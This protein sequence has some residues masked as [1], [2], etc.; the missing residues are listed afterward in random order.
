MEHEAATIDPQ[1]LLM[2]AS[3]VIAAP[4]LKRFGLETVL[5][6]IAAGIAIGP[7]TLLATATDNSPTG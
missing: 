4:L 1:I 2:L 6:Y 3:A 7:M 5:G